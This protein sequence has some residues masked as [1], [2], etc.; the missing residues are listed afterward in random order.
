MTGWELAGDAQLRCE[1]DV[2][3]H[4]LW[5]TPLRGTR[6]PITGELRAKNG[7]SQVVICGR[8]S[9]CKE[10]VLWNGHRSPFTYRMLG[11]HIKDQPMPLYAPPLRAALIFPV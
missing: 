8:D 3:S 2:L 9:D 6:F 11:F 5:S 7:Q 1:E 10:T 4:K